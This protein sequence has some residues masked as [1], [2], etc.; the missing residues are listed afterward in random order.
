MSA[1]KDLD[2]YKKKRDG[3]KRYSEGF[4]LKILSE[5]ST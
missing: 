1:Q 2:M 3:K 5:H 4:K